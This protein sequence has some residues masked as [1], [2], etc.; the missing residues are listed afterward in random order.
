M[1]LKK[2]ILVT[3]GTG[4][5]GK[6]VIQRLLDKNY[7][8]KNFSK[9]LGG[10]ICNLKKL[11]QSMSGCWAVIHLA[12][13]MGV[14][15]KESDYFKINVEGTRNVL[16][17]AKKNKIKKLINVSSIVVLGDGS[18]LY[19]MSKKAALSVANE[20]KKELWLVNVLPT[21]VIDPLARKPVNSNIF[22][23][24]MWFL[25][26][27]IPGGIMSLFGSSKR[28]INYILVDDVADGIVKALENG[29][30]GEDYVLGGEN[31]EVGKYLKKM[32]RLYKSYY[33]PL[34][35]PKFIAERLLGVKF[36]DSDVD[37]NKTK[38]D[39]NFNPH[40]IDE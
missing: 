36:V 1:V 34:R 21:V 22:G 2:T 40:K 17:S 5:I 27:G 35:L 33:L 31:I 29:K 39:L 38:K 32:A 7:E 18:D 3:G 10:D 12:A 26:G 37:I 8:V 14:G 28:R 13:Y 30:R 11:N 20:Y 24:I 23:K 16:K 6:H 9:S 25:G 15:G 4:T 19:A